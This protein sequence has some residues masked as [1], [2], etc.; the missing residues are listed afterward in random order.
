MLQRFKQKHPSLRDKE[1]TYIMK[2]P[3]FVFTGMRKDESPLKIDEQTLSNARNVL[4]KEGRWRKRHGLIPFG[5][6]LP[7]PDPVMRIEQFFKY[8]GTEYLVAFTTKNIYV[9]NVTTKYWDLII[10]KLLIDDCETAWTVVGGAESV[11]DDTWFRYGAYSTKISSSSGFSPG[12]VAYNAISSKNLSGYSHVHFYIKSNIDLDA[13]DLQLLLDD[14]AACT[15]PLETLNIPA[16]TADVPLEVEIA[17]ANAASDTAIISIGLKAVNNKGACS[18]W[19]DDIYGTKCLTA[20]PE[21]ILSCETMYDNDA[22]EVKFIATNG[23]DNIKFWNGSGNWADLAGSPNK[24]KYLKV[25]YTWL[26]LLNC[27][28]SGSQIPQR[29]N[30]CVPGNP[31]DWVGAGSGTNTLSASTGVIVGCEIMRGQLAILLE[32]SITMM[33]ATGS[34]PPFTFDE[35]KILDV[36]CLTGG[37]VQSL[38]E[39]LLFLGWDNIYIF[40]GY[41]CTPVGDS[42]KDFFLNG[43]N[44]GYLNTIFSHIVEGYD[45]YLLFY[46]STD[47]IV[48]DSVLV[49]DYAKNK[50]LSVWDFNVNITGEGYY[51]AGSAKTI[52]GLTMTIGE[53]I[54][55]IGSNM[56]QTLAPYDLLGADNGYV[57]RL[58]DDILNDNGV[59]IDSYID[60]KSFMPNVGKYSRFVRQELYATGTEIES[61]I[62]VDNGVNFI[63]QVVTTLNTDETKPTLTEPFDT[64]NEKSMFRFRNSELNG[65]FEMTGFRYYFIEKEEEV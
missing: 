30:W 42:V 7:L 49:Y 59:L 15:S 47:S 3:Q 23:V 46:P 50:F 8:D 44:S 33:Y 28:V 64:T 11:A 27:T 29:I 56:L 21:D 45:L 2:S 20:T 26:L 58:S 18:I 10:E 25:F 41:S 48:P 60:T 1:K 9:Y 19:I 6:G 16:L 13:G 35:N 36:G 40:D 61:L 31:K 51:S 39:S 5:N 34:T 32:R 22:D 55:R 53:M 65:W 14:T 62:S 54:F 52:G 4:I 24:C 37:S 38:G 43:I 57:Y 17:L 12:L 63:S